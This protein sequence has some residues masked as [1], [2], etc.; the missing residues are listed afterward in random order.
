MLLTIG[1]RDPNGQE[2]IRFRVKLPLDWIRA[3]GPR[4]HALVR[5]LVAEHLGLEAPG[6]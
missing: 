4:P 6:C 3:L 2:R 5:K 1:R